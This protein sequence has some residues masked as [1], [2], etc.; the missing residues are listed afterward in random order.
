[1]PN[2]KK[3]I[4]DVQ[5]RPWLMKL[6]PFWLREKFF[7]KLYL[8]QTTAFPSLFEHASLEFAPQISLKLLPTDISHKQIALVGFYELPVSQRIAKLAK[9][10]GLMVDVGANY[11][12]YSCLWAAAGIENRVVAFEASPRNFS[13]LEFNLI[14]N[15]L[16]PQVAVHQIA[17]GKE[18][19]SLPFTLG[20]DEQSGWGGLLVQGQNDA[21]EVPVV[22]LDDV[23]FETEYERI[24]VLKIDTEGADTWVLQGAEQLLRS[25][26]ISH[27]FFEENYVRMSALGIKPGDA[28]ILLQ[29]CGYHVKKIGA[30]EWYAK[31]Q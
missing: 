17:V 10:G 31:L 1:M 27:I 20:P 16:E 28:Q 19:G 25:H 13:A 30:Y 8:N 4:S 15:K 23:F 3:P 22:S 18:I 21:I 5:K 2:Y 7:W 11:G 26:K 29:N 24:D 12:Y 6:K 9:A 14:E